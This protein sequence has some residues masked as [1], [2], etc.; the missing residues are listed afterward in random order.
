MV[1]VRMRLQF[2]LLFFCMHTSCV[3][4]SNGKP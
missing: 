4:C 2:M 1:K 3:A